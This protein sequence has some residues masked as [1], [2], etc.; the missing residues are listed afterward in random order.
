MQA[1]PVS[2]FALLGAQVWHLRHVKKGLRIKGKEHEAGIL[3]VLNEARKN[4]EE[5][6][7]PV[8]LRA[9]A[10]LWQIK[11]ELA[12]ADDDAALSAEQANRM[13]T[14]G[15]RL[16]DTLKA[17][18]G[19]KMAYVTSDKRY[20]VTR[21]LGDV[22]S[23]MGEGAFDRLPPIARVDMNE[24]GICIAFERPTAAAFHLMRAVEATL[25]HFY[26]CWVRRGRIGEPWNW[27]NVVADMRKKTKPPPPEL[28]DQLDN[29]RRNFRN[30]TQHPEKIYTVDEAQD[31][32]AA[33]V[34]VM[35][36]MTGSPRWVVVKA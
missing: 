10:D 24:A 2:T 30:P 6:G 3:D 29:M 23:L 7:L 26:A 31:L 12:E 34:D 35:N 15:T 19:G 28:L 22:A 1:L 11:D 32:F 17:E 33:A 36:R 21:L 8:T 20:D 4:L 25:R 13:S 16:W 18:M 5:L 9:G 27:G 14:A